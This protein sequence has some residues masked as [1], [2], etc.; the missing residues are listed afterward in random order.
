MENLLYLLAIPALASLLLIVWLLSKV[1][2]GR[3][4]SVTLQA[5]GVSLSIHSRDHTQKEDVDEQQ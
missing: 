2:G 4:M 5:F 1:N 3:A